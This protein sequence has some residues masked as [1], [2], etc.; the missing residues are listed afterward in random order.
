MAGG[1]VPRVAEGVAMLPGCFGS[2]FLRTA[3]ESLRLATSVGSSL[4]RRGGGRGA[5][6]NMPLRARYKRM[7]LRARYKPMPLRARY[8]PMPLR[9]RYKPLVA[10]P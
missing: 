8:K 9:A 5:K 10:T 6:K 3:G 4:I 1:V 7:P 2:M